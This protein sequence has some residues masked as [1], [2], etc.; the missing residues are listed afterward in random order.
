[1]IVHVVNEGAPVNPVALGHFATAL[2]AAAPHEL[3]A[4]EEAANS[5]A[6]AAAAA[7]E[8]GDGAD[9]QLWMSFGEALRAAAGASAPESLQQAASAL[10]AGFP[11]TMGG[12]APT[13]AA[14]TET[15]TE[16]DEDGV[17]GVVD[18]EVEGEGHGKAE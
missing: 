15:E 2:Q 1:M 6:P 10:A 8:E 17:D 7:E 14:E 11:V 3:A 18:E 12:A 13:P 4:A 5:H 16:T 9:A